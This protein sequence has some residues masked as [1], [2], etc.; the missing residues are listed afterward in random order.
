MGW[1]G[2]GCGGVGWGGVVAYMTRC[3]NG[4][5]HFPT[6]VMLMLRCFNVLLHLSCSHRQGQF[7]VKK[8]VNI[9]TVHVHTGTIDN[10]W[11]MIE[12]RLPNSL[13][14]RRCQKAR[15]HESKDLAAFPSLAVALGNST[16]HDLSQL[17]TSTSFKNLK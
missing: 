8:R 13:T 15:L 4:L 17:T 3:F 5:L 2:V 14:T 16:C 1:G 11:K 12:K 6:Y 7:V 10:V 9:K